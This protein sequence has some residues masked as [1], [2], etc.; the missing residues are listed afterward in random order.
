MPE[1]LVVAGCVF[2]ALSERYLRSEYGE[3]FDREGPVKLL[4]EFMH[5]KKK[6]PNEQVRLC[7]DGIVWLSELEGGCAQ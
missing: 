6:T 7:G 4:V 3:N 1:Y 5:G 2:V